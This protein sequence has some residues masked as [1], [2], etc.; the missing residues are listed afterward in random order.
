MDCTV[1]GDYFNQGGTQCVFCSKFIDVKCH[2][3]TVGDGYV[4]CKI[5]AGKYTLQGLLFLKIIN[6]HCQ[7]Y[8]RARNIVHQTFLTICA[9]NIFLLSIYKNVYSM[10]SFNTYSVAFKVISK[11]EKRNLQK[12][13]W[14][15][16]SNIYPVPY[17]DGILCR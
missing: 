13:F 5:C 11:T 6:C 9:C 7:P 15:R 1:C 4:V 16:V 17:P 14:L 3:G 8:S 12:V 10:K 2:G